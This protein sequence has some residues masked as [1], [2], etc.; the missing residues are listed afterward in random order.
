M[1]IGIS[2]HQDRAGI[3][4]KWVRDEIDRELAALPGRHIGYSSL[5]IGSD[6]ILQAP[7]LIAVMI[8]AVVPMGYE[9]CFE[10]V[11]EGIELKSRASVVQLDGTLRRK[12]IL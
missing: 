7:F 5:A 11:P 9:A 12:G 3:D 10:G 8:V 1:I 6:Q 2:G 4:W